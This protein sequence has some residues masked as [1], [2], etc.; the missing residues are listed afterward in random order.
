MKTRFCRGHL[1]ILDFTFEFSD[2]SGVVHVNQPP[3][4]EEK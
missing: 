1:T 4:L 3:V 2:K